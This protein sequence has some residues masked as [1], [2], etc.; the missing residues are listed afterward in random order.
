MKRRVSVTALSSGWHHAL[1]PYYAARGVV[2]TGELLKLEMIRGKCFRP[3]VIGPAWAVLE[4]RLREAGIPFVVS[5]ANG[6]FRL[7]LAGVPQ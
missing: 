5:L 3:A 6:W 4:R 2:G 7:D 1:T